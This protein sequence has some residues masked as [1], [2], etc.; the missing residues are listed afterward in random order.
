[1]WSHCVFVD[2]FSWMASMIQQNCCL[3]SVLP[4]TLPA[5]ASAAAAT[6]MIFSHCSRRTHSNKM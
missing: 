1:M 5:P 4:Q 3:T 6:Q 2:V